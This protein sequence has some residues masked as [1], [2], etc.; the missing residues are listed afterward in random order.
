MK[1]REK[2]YS[3]NSKRVLVVLAKII[4]LFTSAGIVYLLII[5]VVVPA[6]RKPFAEKRNAE[7]AEITQKV[8]ELSGRESEMLVYGR[9]KK[10]ESELQARLKKYN[11]EYLLSH[12]NE[13][14]HTDATCSIS[15]Y[16]NQTIWGI[17]F[18]YS[19]IYHVDDS[20]SS[21]GIWVTNADGSFAMTMYPTLLY[22]NADGPFGLEDYIRSNPIYNYGDYLE[23]ITKVRLKD[24]DVYNLHIHHLVFTDDGF[25]EGATTY[26]YIEFNK[27]KDHRTIRYVRN[28]MPEN[29]F[30]CTINSVQLAYKR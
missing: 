5:G 16:Y 29:D 7:Q 4:A 24:K 9:Q 3:V 13:E 8:N 18:R 28:G 21:S 22:E 12:I 17:S 2:W 27:N 30:F 15:K 20:D 23:G 6:I 14:N 11:P 10:Y 1:K 26:K 25:S 19:G